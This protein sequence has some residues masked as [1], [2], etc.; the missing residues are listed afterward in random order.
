MHKGP[1]PNTTFTTCP[2]LFSRKEPGLFIHLLTYSFTICIKAPTTRQ[3]LEMWKVKQDKTGFLFFWRLC[4]GR[5]G[6]IN[7]QTK[8]QANCSLWE[9]AMKKINRAMW[10]CVRSLREVWGQGRPSKEVWSEKK[11]STKSGSNF[12]PTKT[13]RILFQPESWKQ[14]VNSLFLLFSV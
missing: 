14:A 6:T 13:F 8:K 7:K 10:D 3:K 2:F 1:D 4:F 5:S 12:V 11:G 9:I